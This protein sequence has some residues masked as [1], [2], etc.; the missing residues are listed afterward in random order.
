MPIELPPGT[1]A[2]YS[3][4]NEPTRNSQVL[5]I[6]GGFLGGVLLLIWIINLLANQLVW[7]IPPSVEKQLGTIAVPLFESQAEASPT[8]DTLNQLLDRL[9]AKLPADTQAQRDYQVLYI[10]DSTVNALAIPGDR[11]IIYQGLLDKMSSENELMMVLG[12]ELG[13]FAHRDHLRSLGRG[14]LV[15]LVFASLF[16]DIGTLGSMAVSGIETFTR[17]Q[18]SQAQESQAD[19]FGLDLLVQTYGH[20]A[21]ATDFFADLSEEAGSNFDFLTTHPAPQKRVDRLNQLIEDKGYL[22]LDPEPL[23][24]TLHVNRQ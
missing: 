4:R 15:Q 20:A 5:G 2:A 17:S 6:A 23:P 12:H 19:T 21:G 16:G 3:D 22:L 10:P 18:Y 11:I 9:E 14:I 24:P 1:A 8:Q 7:W 13:H